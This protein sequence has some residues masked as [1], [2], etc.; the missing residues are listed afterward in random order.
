MTNEVV[1]GDEGDEYDDGEVYEEEYEVIDAMGETADPDPEPDDGM[2]SAKISVTKTEHMDM[3]SQQSNT[4]SPPSTTSRPNTTNGPIS[5]AHL[6]L[7]EGRSRNLSPVP[8][9]TEFTSDKYRDEHGMSSAS[10]T[11][12]PRALM[13]AMPGMTDPNAKGELMEK[14]RKLRERSDE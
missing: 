4:E 11:K 6:L 3:I 9:N 10:P 1:A 13:V 12:S 8:Q 5:L 14:L 7:T 2:I